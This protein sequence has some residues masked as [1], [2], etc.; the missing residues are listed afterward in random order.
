MYYYG[1]T[2]VT[3][4]NISYPKSRQTTFFRSVFIR[5]LESSHGSLFQPM[6]LLLTKILSM[7]KER[8]SFLQL[9]AAL[10]LKAC[11]APDKNIEHDNDKRK[12]LFSPA[13]SCL[14]IK[15]G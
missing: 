13:S 1:V 9:A 4:T 3:M 6:F 12:E 11:F 8:N 2:T 15:S 10:L 5:L 14:I 7:T